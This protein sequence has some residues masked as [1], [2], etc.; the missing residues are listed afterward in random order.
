MFFRLK[1][2]ERE[3]VDNKDILHV[4]GSLNRFV[5]FEYGNRGLTFSAFSLAF[6]LKPPDAEGWA[7]SLF[8][9]KASLRDINKPS[10]SCGFLI[11][12]P[13]WTMRWITTKPQTKTKYI[14]YI[15][16]YIFIFVEHWMNEASSSCELAWLSLFICLSVFNIEG[17][18][19]FWWK[20]RAWEVSLFFHVSL[21]VV[22]DVLGVSEQFS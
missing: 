19:L 18:F 3:R 8:S 15:Y 2:R 12:K 11:H 1:E 6:S 4:L 13:D 14:Y 21:K 20:S 7:F 16:M 22:W 10:C 5:L 17:L 9:S